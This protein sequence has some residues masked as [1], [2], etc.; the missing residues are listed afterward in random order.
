MAEAIGAAAALSALAGAAFAKDKLCDRDSGDEGCLAGLLD[1]FRPP[2]DREEFERLLCFLAA[3]PLFQKQ[4]PRDQLPK[5]AHA[6]KLQIWRPGEH[7][8][9]QGDEGRAFFIIRSGEASVVVKDPETGESTVRATLYY[10]DYFG[11]RTLTEKRPNVATIVAK[12]PK[13]LVT[14]S[15]TKDNFE[16][17]GLHKKLMFPK[18]P[19][20][21]DGRRME[22]IM[23]APEGGQAA[24][25]QPVHQHRPSLRTPVLTDEQ[26]TFICKVVKQWPN[27]RAMIGQIDAERIKQMAARARRVEVNEGEDVVKGGALGSEF[28]VVES[29]SL[30]LIPNVLCATGS[31]HRSAEEVVSSTT[32]TERLVRKQQFL[33]SMLHRPTRPVDTVHSIALV[34]PQPP[35]P[36][37]RTPKGGYHAVSMSFE[38]PK[39]EERKKKP[40]WRFL[41]AQGEDTGAG[42]GSN[43]LRSNSLDADECPFKLGDMVAQV[44]IVGDDLQQ[45]VGKVVEIVRHGDQGEVAVEFP[46]PKGREN[47]SVRLLRPVEDWKPIARLD[48]GSCYGELALL[49]NT[50]EVATLRAREACVVYSI[51]ARDFRLCFSKES[52]FHENYCK[53]LDEVHLL[54]PLLRSERAELARNVNG[55]YSFKPRERVVTQDKEQEMLW[56]IIEKGSCRV[57]QRKD[58]GREQILAELHRGGHFGERAIFK[59]ERI[60]E[61]S[62]E[63]GPNGMTCLVVDGEVLKHLWLNVD[64]QVTDWGMP[65]YNIDLDE[66]HRT[67]TGARRRHNPIPL[68][69]LDRIALLGEGGF[70]AVFLV[71][72]NDEEYALKRLSKGWIQAAAAQKQVVAERDVLSMMDCPFIIRLYQTYKDAEYV[73]MLLECANGGHLFHLLSENPDV[74][75]DD[76]PKGAAAMFYV[77]SVIYALEYL[78]ERKIAYRDLKLENIL[79]DSNGFIKLCDL[80][81]SRFVLGKTHTMLGTPEY[82]A[83]EMIDPPHS[84]DHLVDWWGLGVLTYELLTGQ[85]PW[86]NGGIESEDLMSQLMA[87]RDSHDRGLPDGVLPSSLILATDFIKQLLTTNP[88]KR[89]GFRGADQVRAHAWFTS[90]KFSFEA[91]HRREMPVPW[92]PPT[93]NYEAP[94]VR[95]SAEASPDSMIGA[96]ADMS[97]NKLFVPYC[98]DSNAWDDAF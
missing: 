28:I 25:S 10:N 39:R 65:G 8:I 40:R 89:L 85:A 4:L 35:A 52:P 84:H 5:V 1:K 98:A 17:L 86:D 20:I 54:T 95:R 57:L 79:L 58:R 97:D 51:S 45:Q 27:L 59:G 88:R 46:E 76:Q 47:I 64:A 56:Y 14:L 26:Q 75:L 71:R 63:V 80:G 23:S 62:V 69:D 3:V 33:I 22:D 53:L 13:A 9:E 74:L 15:I 38:G 66:Y 6:L 94:A 19:A 78:H 24:A 32:M 48:K 92:V 60:S 21:Y 43:S 81:F 29:G 67:M 11:G 61:F 7:V 68:K 49:Y 41:S 37:P 96:S 2:E 50:R 36:K 18:R 44:V 55:T 93:K 16:R 77:G 42:L 91:L 70:G 72:H 90:R 34:R 82:M 31:R 87:I 12:G 83:P 30:D 73:Y